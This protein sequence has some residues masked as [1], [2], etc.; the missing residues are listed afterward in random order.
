MA[1]GL[2]HSP[3]AQTP[4]LTQLREIATRYGL[5]DM[6][7]EEL[8]LYQGRAYADVYSYLL[9]DKPNIPHNMER[10]VN[11]ALC[12]HWSDTFQLVS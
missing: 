6:P 7:D 4:S 1:D 3:A 11:Y 5:D 8:K 10:L 2:Y 9:M 12:C